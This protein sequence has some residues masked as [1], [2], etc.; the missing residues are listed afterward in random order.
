MSLMFNKYYKLKE[1]IGI[2][3][4][5]TTK[6]KNMDYIFSEYKE[7]DYL[8]LTNF[9]TS[10]IKDVEGMFANCQK[11]KEIIGTDNFNTLKIINM[12]KMFNGSS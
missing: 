4:F 11:L 7:L 8:Y 12:K 6:V 10:N 3:L 5:N 2:N 9:S 1:I